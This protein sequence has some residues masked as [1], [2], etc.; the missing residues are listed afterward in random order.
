[1]FVAVAGAVGVLARYGLSV[2]V[3]S[4]WTT[5][6]INI[7]GSFLLGLLVTLGD[8]LSS[9]VRLVLGVGFL[10][11]FT[12]FS[13]FT[14]QVVIEPTGM[15]ELQPL[16]CSRPSSLGWPRPCSGT[17]SAAHW[18]NRRTSL[19]EAGAPRAS[20]NE[21]LAAIQTRAAGPATGVPAKS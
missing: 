18:S 5:V 14:V 10:G 1:M 9:D 21:H 8:G 12:T 7:V 11:G 15:Q 2:A 6:A 19:V 20:A 17:S 13:T 16:I 4:V 3:Q